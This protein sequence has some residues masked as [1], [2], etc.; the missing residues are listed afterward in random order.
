MA[1]ILLDGGIDVNAADDS[2]VTALRIGV[3]EGHLELVRLIFDTGKVD[4]SIVSNA[5]SL[6]LPLADQTG[7]REVFQYLY[8]MR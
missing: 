5:L 7:H 6:L 8:D 3:Q 1:K 4:G 2:G